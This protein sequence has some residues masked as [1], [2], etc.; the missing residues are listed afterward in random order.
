MYPN[1]TIASEGDQATIPV[2]TLPNPEKV[3]VQEPT[4]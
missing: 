1:D 2:D 4:D 3:V